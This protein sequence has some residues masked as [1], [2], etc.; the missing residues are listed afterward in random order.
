MKIEPRY[1]FAVIGVVLIIAAL[2]LRFYYDV[3]DDMET[4]NLWTS[5]ALLVIGIIGIV[6][7][8][9]FRKKSVTP[10]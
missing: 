6:A 3:P 1:V 10:Q 8:V 7:G 2:F 5:N 4:I 9:L